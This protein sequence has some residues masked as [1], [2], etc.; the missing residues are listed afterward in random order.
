[1]TLWTLADGTSVALHEIGP[2]DAARVQRFVR[3]L[4]DRSR[5]RRFFAPVRELSADLL[6]SVARAAGPRERNVAAVAG[7]E[8]VALAQCIAVTRRE[9]E[10]ALAV[11]DAWQG[12][13][14]GTRLL[15][16]LCDHAREAGFETLAGDVLADNW[17]M[18]ACAVALGFEAIEGGEPDIATVVRRL[19]PSA[20]AA[21]PQARWPARQAE[22]TAV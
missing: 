17:P 14:L 8:I 7:G 3:G 19:E 1:M 5:R 21:V 9:A 11:D 4:S 10:F 18:L 16:T 22:M 20:A 12:L 2:A 13:G 6:A 15:R